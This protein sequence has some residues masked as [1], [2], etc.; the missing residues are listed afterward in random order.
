MGNSFTQF[1]ENL[2][3][4]V[5]N[6]A[7][8][9]SSYVRQNQEAPP[10]LVTRELQLLRSLHD[11]WQYIVNKNLSYETTFKSKVEP[12]G[13][14]ED[15]IS[16]YH[17][18]FTP[19]Y[20]KNIISSKTMNLELPDELKPKDRI[21]TIVYGGAF[22]PPTIAHLQVLNEC[23]NVANEDDD[24]WLLLSGERRD[25]HFTV[26]L[27]ARIALGNALLEASVNPD[28]VYL[29][30]I[31][32]YKKSTVETID[33]MREFAEKYPNR[34]FVWVFG[35]DSLNT[36]LSWY[37]GQWIADNANILIIPRTGYELEIDLKQATWLNMTPLEL[38]STA[39]RAAYEKDESISHM[40]PSTVLD[41]LSIYEDYEEPLYRS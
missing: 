40:V 38:S 31:E 10:E 36:L 1:I 26:N 28:A 12:T 30:T 17:N 7:D 2:Q 29:N 37:E 21:R 34:E 4:H 39:V 27:N 5:N 6:L 14:V 15:F 11:N 18:I 35:V 32:L 33:T 16:F 23:L 19:H 20:G 3:N 13:S 24:V 8:Y 22:N 41:V 9:C 25:K